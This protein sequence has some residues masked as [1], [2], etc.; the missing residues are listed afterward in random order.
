MGG[1][2]A[3]GPLRSLGERHGGLLLVLV[4]AV[5]AGG[6]LLA[7][8]FWYQGFARQ[9]RHE[10][11]A[12]LSAISELKAD[13]LARFRKE[14]L[15]DAQALLQNDVFSDLVRR[16]VEAPG[17]PIARPEL[18][19]WLDL[20]SDAGYTHVPATALPLS[21]DHIHTL[22]SDLQRLATALGV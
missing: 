1:T 18:Q 19:H 14:R 8:R 4:Y 11:E 15:E 9:H 13:D 2:Q 5:V 16:F 7:G 3:D 20:F 12:Q 21:D 17:D 6:V 10:V 22:R